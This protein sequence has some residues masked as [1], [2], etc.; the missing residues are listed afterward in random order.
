MF[1]CEGFTDECTIKS[2]AVFERCLKE[3][4]LGLDFVGAAFLCLMREHSV[5]GIV[6]DEQVEYGAAHGA[7]ILCG[8]FGRFEYVLGHGRAL[9][10]LEYFFE[11]K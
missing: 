6:G 10:D 9:F 5:E 11:R 8:K 2:Q 4:A 3:Q 1:F 7:I